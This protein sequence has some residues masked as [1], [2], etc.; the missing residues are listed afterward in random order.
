MVVLALSAFLIYYQLSTLRDL[1]AEVEMEELA[2]MTARANLNR[3][4][5]HRDRA[6]EYQRRLDFAVRMIPPEPGEDFLLRFFHRTATNLDMRVVEIRF[7]GRSEH[8]DGYTVMPLS[9][10]LEGDFN[11]LRSFL[12]QVYN[13][14]RA[15]RVEDIRLSRA[16]GAGTTLRITMSA[17]AFYNPNN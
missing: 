9:I 14:E 16:G 12:R 17:T 5:D 1:R 7:G 11:N 3:L 6:D 2:V 13:A 15:I 8:E 10:V 4:I